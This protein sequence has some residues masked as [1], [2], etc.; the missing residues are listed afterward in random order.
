MYIYVLKLKQG[1][2]Y[3][4]KTKKPDYRFD[5][6]LKSHGSSW[7]KKYKPIKI[8]EL[9]EGDKFDEDK[10]VMKYMDKYGIE[11]VRGGS[12]SSVKLNNMQLSLLKHI[13]TSTNDKCFKCGKP[14]HFANNCYVNIDSSSDE[15]LEE[16]QIYNIDGKELLWCNGEW[17]KEY[18]G[19]GRPKDGFNLGGIQHIDQD[20]T[21]VPIKNVSRK[22]SYSGK[23]YRCG[24]KGH[25]SNNCYAKT[26]ISGKYLKQ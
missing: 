12:Y 10:Y 5:D 21:W 23:C 7:T 1:K 15:E 13:N 8:L 4:G 19:Y 20:I 11:N 17:N 6:H 2:Y 18:T 16:E 14:G 22:K 25:Y 24:R 3:V 26:H 9:F